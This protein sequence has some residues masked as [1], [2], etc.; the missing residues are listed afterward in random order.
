M[1][2]VI[3]SWLLIVL[4]LGLTVFFVFGAVST[5]ENFRNSPGW[6]IYFNVMAA[7]VVVC[8]VFGAVTAIHRSDTSKYYPATVTSV[9]VSVI[10]D[11]QLVE[12]DIVQNDDSDVDT[13]VRCVSSTTFNCATVKRGDQVLVRKDYGWNGISYHH[14]VMAPASK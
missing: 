10:D 4:M 9:S 1:L 5:W 6:T 3:L 7:I 13:S 14:Y 12:L 8:V 11:S 2:Y